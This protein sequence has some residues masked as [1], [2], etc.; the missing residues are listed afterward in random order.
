MPDADEPRPP[1]TKWAYCTALF[2]KQCQNQ[3][4]TLV[5][6]PYLGPLV[7]NSWRS[8]IDVPKGLATCRPTSKSWPSPPRVL[9]FPRLCNYNSDLPLP[10]EGSTLRKYLHEG[11]PLRA[12]EVYYSRFRT[13]PVPEL[14]NYGRSPTSGKSM[15]GTRRYAEVRSSRVLFRVPSIHPSQPITEPESSQKV[16]E[17]TRVDAVRFC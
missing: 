4:L 15:V 13:W 1:P 5:C 8:P 6:N 10:H 3:T 11:V 2:T 16:R 14:H 9:W 7:A 12:C 17:G